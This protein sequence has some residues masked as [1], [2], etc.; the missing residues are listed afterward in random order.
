VSADVPPP[1]P[2]PVLRADELL[3]AISRGEPSPVDDPAGDPVVA[4]LADWRAELMARSKQL[5]AS[6]EIAATGPAAGPVGA[7]PAAQPTAG[8]PPR[9]PAPAGPER[10]G[11]PRRVSPAGPTSGRRRRGRRPAFASATLA[12]V[13]V[14]GGL[15]F[16]AARAEPGGLFWP[17]TKLVFAERAESLVTER[18][19]GRMLDEARQDLADG[20]HADARRHL[21]RAAG[22]V[23]TIGED[24]TVTRLRR[25]IEELRRLL[26]PPTPAD[27]SA[28]RPNLGAG[29]VPVP[30]GTDPAASTSQG[31]PVT[32]PVPAPTPA[33]PTSTA[34][35]TTRQQTKPAPGTP[36]ARPT[37]PAVHPKRHLPPAA[38]PTVPPRGAQPHPDEATRTRPRATGPRFDHSAGPAQ[39]RA[40]R[41]SRDRGTTDRARPSQA[42][43]TDGT[44]PERRPNDGVLDRQ[45][46]PPSAPPA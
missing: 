11:P 30:S 34:P 23:G 33:E 24:A 22:L 31:P 9:Q 5:E 6:R 1:T 32:A 2:D 17:V 29:A 3:D 13:T 37:A 36:T 39:A 14:V 7:T 8:T 38:A 25:D 18:E 16:G 27:P 44:G 41:A 42:A 40:D 21:E 28:P 46:R 26:P 43:A 4:L 10:L 35:A 19:I 20:R 12:L 15:W 45:V